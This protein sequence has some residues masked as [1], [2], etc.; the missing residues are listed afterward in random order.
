[1]KATL[2]PEYAEYIKQFGFPQGAIF[3]PDK[4]AFVLRLLNMN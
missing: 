4:L 2:K 1:M 3:E